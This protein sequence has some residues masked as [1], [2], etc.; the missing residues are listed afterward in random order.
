MT[1]GL[2]R[3]AITSQKTEWNVVQEKYIAEFYWAQ[4]DGGA[5]V[6]TI[7]LATYVLKMIMTMINVCYHQEP[8]PLLEFGRCK[9]RPPKLLVKSKHLVQCLSWQISPLVW[10]NCEYKRRFFPGWVSVENRRQL[11]RRWT[12][13]SLFLLSL[14][15][16]CKFLSLYRFLRLSR[17]CSGC[18]R[19]W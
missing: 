14:P 19:R 10:A 7:K 17:N 16:L 11:S 4:S 5:V 8:I 13:S 6:S 2:I 9:C 12:R 1:N 18:V 15:A 3:D